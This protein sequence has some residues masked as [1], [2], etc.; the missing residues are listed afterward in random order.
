[1]NSALIFLRLFSRGLGL[2]KKELHE[3]DCVVM[4]CIFRGIDKRKGCLLCEVEKVFYQVFF[5]W[6]LEFLVIAFDECFPSFWFVREPSA[7]S[8]AGREVFCPQI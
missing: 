6:A 1:M 5:F 2:L 7:Q 3:S 8:V 4:L